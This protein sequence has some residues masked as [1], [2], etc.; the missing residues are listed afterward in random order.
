MTAPDLELDVVVERPPALVW[1][2]VAD[3]VRIAAYSPEASGVAA[4]GG[5]SGGPLTVGARFRG[6]NRNGFFRWSTQCAVVEST[7]GEAFAF[8][9]SYLGMSVARWRFVLAPEGEAT[10]VVQQWTDRRGIT[11]KALGTVGTGVADRRT[12]NERTM[13]ATLDA[14]KA[15]LEDR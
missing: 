6:S 3:P 5:T 4:E 2:A 12:H 13:R 11:M 15:D 10:R 14:L 8:D 7:A 9:V 1:E